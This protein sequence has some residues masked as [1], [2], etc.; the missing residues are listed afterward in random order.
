MNTPCIDLHVHSTASDGTF[1][2]S[3]LIK[4][5]KENNLQAIALTDHDSI[6]G[7][8]EASNESAKQNIEFVP[9]IEL[10]TDHNGKEL[11]VV[12]L[13]I[14]PT[15]KQLNDN[16]ITFVN[17]RDSRNAKMCELL[18]KEG[19]DITMEKLLA[20]AGTGVLTRAHFAN[21]LVDHGYVKN[22]KAVFH[23]YLGNDCRCFVDRTLIKTTNAIHL[24]KQAGGV[25]ILAHPG[26]YSYGDDKMRNALTE[27]KAAG[28][29][30]L[31]AIYSTY[32][33]ADERYFKGLAKE[34]D[35]LI[36]GGSDFHGTNKPDIKLGTGK[37]SMFISYEILQTIKNYHNRRH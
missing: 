3:K 32:T 19:F 1:T 5:A 34:Y 21:Y 24:I 33:P 27:F 10:S 14:D 9:G 35:L 15:N 2:P 18:Q 25:A 29:D 16:L 12:G 7:L 6:D 13:Y 4:L 20:F 8:A 26:L 11:H 30:G 36:S 31:E 37:G 22:I 23:E 17:E 28:L